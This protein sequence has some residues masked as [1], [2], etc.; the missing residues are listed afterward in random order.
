MT[1]EKNN[2]CPEKQQCDENTKAAWTREVCKKVSAVSATH[3]PVPSAIGQGRTEEVVSRWVM[4]FL[5]I[6]YVSH[7]F[8]IVYFGTCYRSIVLSVWL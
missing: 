8:A 7:G 4:S 5:C 3:V 1:D 2:S 6:W